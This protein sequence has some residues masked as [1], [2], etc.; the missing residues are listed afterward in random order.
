[1]LR[2]IEQE[3]FGKDGSSQA[4]SIARIISFSLYQYIE[5][6]PVKAN[7]VENS[8]DYPWPG[9][10]HNAL[11]EKNSLITEHQLYRNLGDSSAQRAKNYQKIFATRNSAEQEQRI[12]EATMRGEVYGS[13]EFHNKISKLIPIATKLTAH[14]GDRKSQNY[15][16]QAG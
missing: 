5:I 9:Y 8:A 16:N 13:R 15:R 3:L 2:V 4:G 10:R 12:T 11:G 14:G 7:I 6:N 1:M